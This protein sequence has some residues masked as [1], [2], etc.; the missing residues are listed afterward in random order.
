MKVFANTMRLLNNAV[1]ISLLATL[2]TLLSCRPAVKDIHPH[3]LH[4]ARL[5]SSSPDVRARVPGVAPSEVEARAFV[6]RLVMQTV[7]DGLESQARS[8]LLPD[9]IISRILSQSTVKLT[10]T[11][12][13][14]QAVRNSP[15]EMAISLKINISTNMMRLSAGPFMISL[16]TTISTVFGCGVLPAGQMTTKSFTISDLTNLPVAMVYTT[17]MNAGR[18]SGISTNQE[19][20][21]AFVSRLVMQTIFDVLEDH[22]H[23][24]LLPDSVI[25][26]ILN[27]LTVNITYEPMLCQAIILDLAADD[28][29]D[30]KPQNCIIVGSTVTGIC[31]KKARNSK[32]DIAMMGVTGIPA[33]HSRIIGTL[34]ITNIVMANWSNMMWQSIVNRAVRMLILGPFGSH[35]FSGRVTVGGS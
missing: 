21:K 30:M 1:M 22:G 15:E 29:D 20:A 10:Y 25:S 9:A 31:I 32:C 16:L 4:F 34:A 14:C 33:A 7:F 12:M 26:S 27:Q 17:A 18:V 35:F 5:Y 24:A 6:K 13:L 23:S 2:S 8:A 3:R 11:P 28:V 19:G